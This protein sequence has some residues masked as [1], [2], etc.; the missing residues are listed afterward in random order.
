VVGGLGRRDIQ[1]FHCAISE[2]ETELA[3]RMAAFLGLAVEIFPFDIRLVPGVLKTLGRDY[4]FP[5]ATY[6][7]RKPSPLSRFDRAHQTHRSPSAWVFRSSMRFNRE[8]T[9]QHR[10]RRRAL[11]SCRGHGASAC[12]C[13]DDGL[14][15]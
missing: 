10:L 5:F 13:G 9:Q 1:L 7:T 2:A 11:G 6:S 14:R 15:A 8:E 12:R 3:R 4:R